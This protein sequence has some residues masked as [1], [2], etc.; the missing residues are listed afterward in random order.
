MI[1]SSF[2]RISAR[3]HSDDGALKRN[4]LPPS[5]VGVKSRGDF[6]QGSD[7]AADRNAA[8]LGPQDPR[9]QFEGRGLSCPIG[10]NDPE[11]LTRV[12]LE[13]EI[14]HGPELSIAEVC[15]RLRPPEYPCG[16]RRKEVP[17]AVVKLATPEALRNVIDTD[18]GG[19]TCSAKR[20]SA[21]WN[22]N[23]ATTK[24]MTPQAVL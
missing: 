5:Q 3:R 20:N 16:K 7:A 11:G 2:D 21:R 6:N 18:R 14:L 9:E 15:L 24:P 1:A 22:S 19:H 13:R 12:N 8:T 10:S 23:D 4:I 17:E